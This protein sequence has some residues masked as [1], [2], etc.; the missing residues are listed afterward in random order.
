[1]YKNLLILLYN[2][3]MDVRYNN[4]NSPP[5]RTQQTENYR[6]IASTYNLGINQN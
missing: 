5:S 6:L 4:L 1:M 2:C 3:R